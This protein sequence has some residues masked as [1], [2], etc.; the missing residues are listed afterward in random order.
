MSCSAYRWTMTP[1][2]RPRLPAVEA[3]F[4][5]LRERPGFLEHGCNGIP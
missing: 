3:W 5:R 2:E 1:M 4:D